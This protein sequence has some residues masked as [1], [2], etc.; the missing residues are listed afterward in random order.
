VLT[1]RTEVT[2][3]MLIFDE[4]HLR[5]VLAEYARRHWHKDRR[6]AVATTW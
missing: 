3:L 5:K 4:R 2:D 6:P 1:A